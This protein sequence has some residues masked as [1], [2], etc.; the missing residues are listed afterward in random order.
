M[1]NMLV[2]F[3]DLVGAPPLLIGVV[4]QH[5]GGGMSVV[6]LLGGGTITARGQAVAV[7]QQAYVRDGVIEGQAPALPVV[8]IEV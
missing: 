1:S 7:G 6:Q 2:R 3:R 5:A 8:P 4:V